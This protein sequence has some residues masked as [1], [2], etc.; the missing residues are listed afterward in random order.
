ME[1]TLLLDNSYTPI[2]TISWQRAITL[3]TLGKVEIIE[4]YD[5]DIRSVHVIFK[6]PAVARLVNAFR[7]GRKQ[8][9]F[10][11]TNIL[12]RDRWKCQYCSTKVNGQTM[13]IDHVTPRAQGGITKWE[14]VVAC[15]ED[16]N[17]K[18][19]NRTPAQ[20]GMKL[21]KKPVKPTWVPVFSISFSGSIPEQWMSYVYWA[22]ELSS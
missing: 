18:K 5:K 21:L 15:C 8:V 14:N 6:M 9:K 19:A 1:R 16:C 7:R 20:A 22:G 3:L 17:S 2:A 13:T 11:R 4:E 12:A 10:S